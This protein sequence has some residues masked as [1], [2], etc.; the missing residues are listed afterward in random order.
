[1]TINPFI[2]LYVNILLCE[3]MSAGGAGHINSSP[4]I[5]LLWDRWLS[6]LVSLNFSP[7]VYKITLITFVSPPS[8]MYGQQWFMQ[9][10]FVNSKAC[11]KDKIQQSEISFHLASTSTCLLRTLSSEIFMPLPPTLAPSLIWSSEEWR[12][13]WDLCD[14]AI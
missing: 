3:E 7:V 1:M 5:C 9:K 2:A 14:E 12:I 10:C 8:E 4:Q 13:L 6:Y 11:S